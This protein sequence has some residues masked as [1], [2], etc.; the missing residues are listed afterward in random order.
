MLDVCGSSVHE[1]VSTHGTSGIYRLKQSS[2][3]I[4]TERA[5][6][7]YL[8]YVPAVNTHNNQLKNQCIGH[9]KQI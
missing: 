6:D 9:H 8:K 3:V 7:V 2:H 4:A 5:V 1:I